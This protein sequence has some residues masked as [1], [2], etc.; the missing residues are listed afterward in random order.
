MHWL[1]LH[2]RIVLKNPRYITCDDNCK[3]IQLFCD[4]VHDVRANVFLV[5]FLFLSN[6][7]RDN[8]CT[9]F[10][11]VLSVMHDLAYRLFGHINHLSNHSNAQMFTFPNNFTDFLKIFFGF[12]CR[13]ASQMFVAVHFLL[14]FHEPSVS[15]KNSCA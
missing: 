3:H 13:R 1:P 12:W 8:F 4:S 2:F 5:A 15:F 7:F 6:V 11:H 9:D 10:P 14:T